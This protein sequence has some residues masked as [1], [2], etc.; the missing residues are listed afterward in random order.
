MTI[1]GW[2]VMIVSVGGICLLLGW[3]VIR[4]VNDPNASKHI[5]SPADI[6]PDDQP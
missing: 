6:H 5:H 2:I 1:G 3:C 4:V